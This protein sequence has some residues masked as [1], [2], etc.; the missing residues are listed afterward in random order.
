LLRLADVG[1]VRNLLHVAAPSGDPSSQLLTLMRRQGAETEGLRVDIQ[2]GAVLLSGQ[3]EGWFDRDAAERLAW[4]LPAVHAVTNRITLPA[5]AVEPDDGGG[6]P[7][8]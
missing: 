8:S 1:G 4:T 5:E 7:S 2:D 3:A 6:V